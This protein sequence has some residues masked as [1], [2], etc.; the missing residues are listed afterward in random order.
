MHIPIQYALTYPER[1]EGIKSES[2]SFLDAKRFDF[3]EPDLEKFPC[4]KFAYEAGRMGGSAPICLNAANEEAVFAFLKG[5]I[6]LFKI[7]EIVE[8]MLSEH[9]LI[10]NPSI[11]EILEIDNELRIKTNEFINTLE[12]G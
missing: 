10:K 11:D 8:K 3:E 6:R 4:L 7:S 2:F 12:R 1:F 5:K 9:S